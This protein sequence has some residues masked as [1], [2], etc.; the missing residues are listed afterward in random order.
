MMVEADLDALSSVARCVR[1]SGRHASTFWRGQAGR[2]H[3][4]RGFLGSF[5]VDALGARGCAPTFVPR[6]R[7]YDLRRSRTSSR[8]LRGARPDVIIHLAAVVGGIGANREN[9]G[10][11]STTT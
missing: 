4:R 9:P 2:G 1:R 7:D 11:S 5:V 3:R 6:S 10:R 8:L